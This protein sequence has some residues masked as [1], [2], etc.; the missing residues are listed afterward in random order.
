MPGL[1]ATILASLIASASL[2][3]FLLHFTSKLIACDKNRDGS[4]PL[5]LEECNIGTTKLA[6]MAQ[7]NL[8]RLP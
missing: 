8:C 4:I 6:F 5:G 2:A 7:S 3:S 1:E